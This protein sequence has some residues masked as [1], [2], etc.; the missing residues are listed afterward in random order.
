MTFFDFFR[1]EK[2]LLIEIS[3]RKTS[4]LLLSLDSAKKLR[5][6]KFWES[7]KESKFLGYL[8]GIGTIKKTIIAV[9]ISGWRIIKKIKNPTKVRKDKNR[10]FSL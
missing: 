5:L 1:K 8:K 4:G 3:R 6:E 9:P 7:P 2:F 10:L